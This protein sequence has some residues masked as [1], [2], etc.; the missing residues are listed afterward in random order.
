MIRRPPRSTLF[1]YTTLFR[2]LSDNLPQFT[3]VLVRV[4][5]SEPVKTFRRQQRR[6]RQRQRFEQ[7][8]AEISIPVSHAVGRALDAKRLPGPAAVETQ[9]DA[10]RIHPEGLHDS[11]HH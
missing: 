10:L 11:L 4:P 7:A 3:Q 8:I 5:L 9:A 2:S 1:P 6:Q